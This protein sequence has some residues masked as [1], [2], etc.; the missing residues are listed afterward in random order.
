MWL[1]NA[2]GTIV[3]LTRKLV[4]AAFLE[5]ICNIALF[6]VTN[7]APPPIPRIPDNVPAVAAPI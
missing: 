5:S 4:P 2:T 6:I 3:E 7:T 1:T